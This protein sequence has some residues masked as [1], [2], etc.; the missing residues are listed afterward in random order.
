MAALA[1]AAISW[2]AGRAVPPVYHAD[3]TFHLTREPQMVAQAS[4]ITAA[5]DAVLRE[6]D[7]RSEIEQAA[8]GP[9]QR[10]DVAP[11]N[12]DDVVVSVEGNVPDG[13]LRAGGVI[14]DR[15]TA[16]LGQQ[17]AGLERLVADRVPEPV[18]KTTRPYWKVPVSVSA[19]PEPQ[20]NPRNFAA[21]GFFCGA[22]L[23]VIALALAARSGSGLRSA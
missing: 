7:V 17:A 1:G 20:R 21:A 12:R 19:P 15:V 23:A 13:V 9:L 4:V 6:P 22:G 5:I 8:G 11:V 2:F 3:I 14:A 16:R 10:L 18:L